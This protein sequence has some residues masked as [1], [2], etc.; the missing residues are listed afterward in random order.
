MGRDASELYEQTTHCNSIY[1]YQNSQMSC[2]PRINI[3]INQKCLE[4][5]QCDIW[6]SKPSQLLIGIAYAKNE[7]EFN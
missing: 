5:L 4:S 1:S 7:P 6:Q 3:V 2:D